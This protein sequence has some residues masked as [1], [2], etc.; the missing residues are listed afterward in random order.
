MKNYTN[1][2]RRISND[3][4]FDINRLGLTD[5]LESG[6]SLTLGIDYKKKK[7]KI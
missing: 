6:E 7:S 4:I 2:N 5:T 1:E 3:N